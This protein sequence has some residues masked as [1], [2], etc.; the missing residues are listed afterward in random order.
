MKIIC[1]TQI[2]A[3]CL[4]W[5]WSSAQAPS[6]SV[7]ALLW[8]TLSPLG[9][10][11]RTRGINPFRACESPSRKV[12]ERVR[13]FY[14]LINRSLRNRLQGKLRI[15]N[16]WKLEELNYH[17]KE[18][19]RRKRDSKREIFCHISSTH[20]SIWSEFSQINLVVISSYYPHPD[21]ELWCTESVLELRVPAKE[22][23][24]HIKRKWRMVL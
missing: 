17:S 4:G 14:S 3:L 5:R 21:V 13:T 1:L 12:L 11:E 22:L 18:I 23:W 24:V 8:I 20:L 7:T 19:S 16:F 10:D 15:K 2:R 9:H 6:S